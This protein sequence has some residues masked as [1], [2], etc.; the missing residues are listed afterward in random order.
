M[1]KKLFIV[2][3]GASKDYNNKILLGADLI[4]KIQNLKFQIYYEVVYLI[5]VKV[6][7]GHAQ[8]SNHSDRGA[9][10][11]IK[12]FLPK[13]YIFY[14]LVRNED[15]QHI[16]GFLRELT[17][18]VFDCQGELGRSAKEKIVAECLNVLFEKNIFSGKTT[19]FDLVKFQP[20]IAKE[21]DILS[22]LKIDSSS[23]D[24]DKRNA[25]N[26]SLALDRILEF[27]F[28]PIE[29][30][31]DLTPDN[32][33][34]TNYINEKNNVIKKLRHY[35]ICGITLSSI[36]DGFDSQLYSIDHI[37]NFLPEVTSYTDDYAEKYKLPSVDELKEFAVGCVARMVRVSL[38]DAIFNRKENWISFIEKQIFLNE[39]KLIKEKVK[40]T[41]LIIFNYDQ[42][43][44]LHFKQLASTYN[45][46][47]RKNSLSKFI[48]KAESSHVY[49]ALERFGGF[50]IVVGAIASGLSWFLEDLKI[51]I[52]SMSFTKDGDFQKTEIKTSTDEIKKISESLS[53]KL[54]NK[55]ISFIRT[56]PKPKIIEEHFKKLK[57]NETIY[58]LGFGFDKWNLFNIGIY[59]E[60]FIVTKAMA[61]LKNKTVYVTNYQDLPKIRLII[62]KIFGVKLYKESESVQKEVKYSFWRS[63]KNKRNN[64]VFVST[65]SVYKALVEDFD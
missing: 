39:E 18:S 31:E 36:I 22:P 64:N 41:D 65:K 26:F 10:K 42:L 29:G 63:Y 45:S 6:G 13:K 14:Q 54:S 16:E 28:E 49:G 11:L 60:N 24:Y 40:E 30:K 2:G 12:D 59:D 44:K 47:I 4:T 56:A 61:E 8:Q 17:E 33:D 57:E 5:A 43:V 51:P 21:I 38:L 62:E 58:F 53:K 27:I 50:E 23:T 35:I 25:K 20:T 48:T 9:N 1:D 32:A 37:I 7:M 52:T 15:P 55:D 3:A 19:F 46:A 34:Y